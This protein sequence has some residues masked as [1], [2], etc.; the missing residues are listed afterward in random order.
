MKTATT[1]PTIDS[2]LI[3]SHDQTNTF[4]YIF[5]GLLQV[6]ALLDVS[7]VA[8][9]G[10]KVV[11]A[12][13]KRFAHFEKDLKPFWKVPAPARLTICLHSRHHRPHPQGAHSEIYFSF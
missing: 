4:V 2:L 3:A 6:C 9:F 12:T 11:A 10:V 5:S 1:N 7:F 13:T 8:S